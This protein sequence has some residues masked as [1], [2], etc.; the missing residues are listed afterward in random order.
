MLKLHDFFQTKNP[1]II[2]Y[3][4]HEYIFEGFSLLSHYKLENVSIL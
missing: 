1:T 2:E 4:N 3:D